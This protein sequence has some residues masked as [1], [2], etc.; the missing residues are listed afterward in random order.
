MLQDWYSYEITTATISEIEEFLNVY[1]FLISNVRT[2][3][4][5]NENITFSAKQ[6]KVIH[7]SEQQIKFLKKSSS[8]DQNKCVEE[9][10]VQGKAGSGKSSV[11]S[12]I[13]HEVTK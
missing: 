11:I 4:N 6:N 9:I 3:F 2:N 13:Y 7:T 5:S 1:K 12:E 10:I 8:W